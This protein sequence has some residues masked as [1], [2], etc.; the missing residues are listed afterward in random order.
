[1]EKEC[2]VPQRELSGAGSD[3]PFPGRS[4]FFTKILISP[5]PKVKFVVYI[6]REE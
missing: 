2:F 4:E 3:C 5:Q 6:S 1:M